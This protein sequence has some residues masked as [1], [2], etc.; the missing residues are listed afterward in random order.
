[1]KKVC[2]YKDLYGRYHDTEA[3]C[4]KV[5]LDYKMEEVSRKLD[6][7]K[8]DIESYLFGY[9][10]RHD[11]D[12]HIEWLRGEERIMGVVAKQVLLHSDSFIEIITSKKELEKDLDKLQ[13]Q[14]NSWW[15]KTKWW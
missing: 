2:G 12:T 8:S 7:F 14:R 13:K 9:N 3:A 4:E 15:L 5:D 1:M 11:H 6:R 10:S